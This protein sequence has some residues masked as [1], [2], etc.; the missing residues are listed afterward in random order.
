MSPATNSN[1]TVAKISARLLVSVETTPDVASARFSSPPTG[2]DEAAARRFPN[3]QW[4]ISMGLP[5]D[6]PD[7][8]LG[9]PAVT[10]PLPGGQA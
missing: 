5:E 7:A 9:S 8:S 6:I 10:M 2:T 4:D 1:P 3:D